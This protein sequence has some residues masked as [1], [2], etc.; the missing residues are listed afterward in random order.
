MHADNICNRGI[1]ERGVQLEISSGLMKMLIVDDELT[2][3][4]DY[5]ISAV[6]R[7]WINDC[8]DDYRSLDV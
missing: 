7:F 6:Q 2:E 8:L 5:L 3:L 1:S 4:G